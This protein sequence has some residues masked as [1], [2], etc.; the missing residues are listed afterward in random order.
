MYQLW[1]VELRGGTPEV[2]HGGVVGPCSS[3]GGPVRAEPNPGALVGLPDLGHPLPPL[4]P[5]Y[6][7]VRPLVELLLLTVFL[8]GPSHGLS[9]SL[10][11]RSLCG[12]K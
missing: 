2:E 5:S 7:S 10:C 4:P 12:S 11:D 1:E 9:L 3:E 6:P 8:I